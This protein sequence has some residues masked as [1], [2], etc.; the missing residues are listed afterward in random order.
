MRRHWIGNDTV[1]QDA[2]YSNVP[3][4]QL[5]PLY[6]TFYYSSA[7]S[8]VYHGPYP[9]RADNMAVGGVNSIRCSRS[10]IVSQK[11]ENMLF[12]NCKET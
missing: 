2:F 4:V 10:G 8:A 6:L 12:Q 11:C 9:G 3:I 7:R 5:F 1:R